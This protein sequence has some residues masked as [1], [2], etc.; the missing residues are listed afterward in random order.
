MVAHVLEPMQLYLGQRCISLTETIR[1]VFLLDL[2]PIFIDILLERIFLFS[3]LKDI[4]GALSPR[5]HLL[6]Y[7]SRLCVLIARRQLEGRKI[8]HKLIG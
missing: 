5:I 3:A 4:E 6:R 7:S 1:V 2:L 8:L